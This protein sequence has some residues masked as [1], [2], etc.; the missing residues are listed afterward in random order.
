MKRMALMT[1]SLSILWLFI[2]AC[3]RAASSE[4]APPVI[5]YGEDICEFCG[6]IIS[7]ERYAAGYLTQDGEERIFDDIGGMFAAYL[8]KQEEATAFFVHDYEDTTWIRAET[9]HYVFS[10]ELPTPMRHGLAACAT[11]A[12]A[13]ALAAEFSGS[14]LTFDE[15]MAHYRQKLSMAGEHERPHQPGHQ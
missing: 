8:Q 1:L 12:R 13:Q 14:V 15:V 11:P 2:T 6:M 10:E 9:A 5:H 4:P 3:G 7:D